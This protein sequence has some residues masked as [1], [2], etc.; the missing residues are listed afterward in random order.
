MAGERSMWQ[1]GADWLAVRRPT[2]LAIDALILLAAS[3]IVGQA[4]EALRYVD[5][6]VYSTR[7]FGR[8][9]FTTT[10]GLAIVSSV[11]YYAGA[12]AAAV[13]CAR[14]IGGSRDADRTAVHDG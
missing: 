2:R 5:P 8:I 13:A 9:F 11:L 1:I 10:S 3:V 14:I 6:E 7:S 4:H 12:I